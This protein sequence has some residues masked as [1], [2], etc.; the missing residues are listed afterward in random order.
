MPSTIEKLFDFVKAHPNV[1]CGVG[2][3]FLPPLAAVGMW[4]LTKWPKWLKLILTGYTLVWAIGVASSSNVPSKTESA[5]NTP[6]AQQKTFDSNK[7]IVYSPGIVNGAVLYRFKSSVEGKDNY[8]YIA[9]TDRQQVVNLFPANFFMSRSEFE[10]L[11]RTLEYRKLLTPEASDE[12][13]HLLAVYQWVG[14]APDDLANRAR[15][16]AFQK[17]IR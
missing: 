12:L 17:C 5:R 2:F 1:S 3:I 13:N 7:C 4:K 9:F 10:Q 15:P 6:P 14:L 8:L 16:T 11:D